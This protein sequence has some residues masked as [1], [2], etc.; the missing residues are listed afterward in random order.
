MP[1]DGTHARN[2][3]GPARRRGLQ[4]WFAAGVAI[5]GVGLV[6]A[7]LTA[8][9]VPG[10]QE[11]AVR[12][13]SGD[14]ADTPLGD[15]TALI[16][17]T[18][19]NPLA[20]PA[21]QQ[22]VDQLY[23]APRG[24]D[25]T[26]QAPFTPEGLY[27]VTGV[28]SL[29]FDTSAAQEQQILDAAIHTQ[30]AGGGVEAANPVVVFGWSQSA[31]FSGFT[32]PEL[33][34]EGVPSGDVHFVMVGDAYNPNGG[35]FERFDVPGAPLSIPSLGIVAAGPTPDD[36]FPTDI[37]TNEYDGFADF[38]RYPID[39]LSDLNAYAGILFD[40]ITYL[41]LDP[42]QIADAIQ[43]PTSAADTLTN[44]YMIPET[45][46][47]LDF[48]RFLPVIGNPL[49]D[50]LQPD[51]SVLVNLGYGSITDGWDPGPAD[52]ATPFELF[53]T[54]LNWGDV[55]TA[56]ANGVPQ[57]ITAA[58]H[59][60]QDPADYQIISSILDN[61]LTNQL[62]DVGHIVGFTDATNLTQLLDY[63]SLHDAIPNLLGVAQNA[64]AGFANFPI[65]HATLLSSPTDL[66]NDLSATLSYD[67]STLLPIADSVNTLL[68][69]LP[70]YDLSLFIDGLQAGNLLAA[71]GDP[72]AADLALA[73]FGLGFAAIA[74]PVEALA[75]TLINLV[76]LIPGL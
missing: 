32:E 5:A 59:D 33:A 55:L 76:D 21:Y 43:L 62:I 48:L 12:L 8:S 3:A 13:T 67:Y 19:G 52:M 65:S 49:A 30:I 74:P 15:G 60:L 56:L 58:L 41:G 50:L 18:S 40:H 34:A 16:F 24:F 29:P 9:P 10:R 20:V 35:L 64:L 47:L 66:I 6:A 51:M 36:L 72:I 27:P 39:F 38:P 23:L 57:G 70:A 61:P 63:P 46:P 25:G 2:D 37:Y 42:S 17:G 45:L 26:I 69:T 68:T 14:A 28:K 22:A 11:R 7:S 54:N 71:I 1:V 4:L 53:P 73:P 31:D 44:Y 75:G